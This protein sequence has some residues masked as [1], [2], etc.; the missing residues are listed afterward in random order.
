MT[1]AAYLLA[2]V[3]REVPS[4][5][6]ALL[7]HQEG[8]ITRP[9][10][11]E[12]TTDKVLRRL[13][14]EDWLRPLTSGVFHRPD[15]ERPVARAWAGHLMAGTGS[16]LGGRAVLHR[17]GI[18]AAPETVPVWLPLDR[19]P[20]RGRRGWSFH[21]DGQDRLARVRGTL[22]CIRVEE[23][24]IDVGAG[25]DLE[26]WVG[27]VLDAVA[28]QATSVASVR[29]TLEARTRGHDRA[30]R[31]EVLGDLLGLESS[32]EFRYARDVERAHGLPVGERQ[33]SVSARTRTD[34]RLTA[35]DTLV[36]LDGRLGHDGSGVLRDLWR[37][38]AHAAGGEVTF[39]YGSVDLRARP[40]AVAFQVWLRVRS[41]G[42]PEPLKRCRRCPPRAELER[43]A[44]AAGWPQAA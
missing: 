28:R 4:A 11:M 30:E 18:G 35:W 21:L 24:L 29:S 12:H 6:I 22:P 43:Q 27:L 5:L 32:L 8:V 1:R 33:V 16:A 34:V 9:Q 20:L 10:V 39:R 26:T 25:Q 17:A 40:C 38:N 3:R 41:Q 44:S 42:W 7:A 14:R 23:A 19:S 36:E 2:Y 13:L 37:D 15:T 31:L